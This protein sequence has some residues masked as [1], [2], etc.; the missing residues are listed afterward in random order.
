[1]NELTWPQFKRLNHIRNLTEQQQVREYRFYLDALSNERLRQ[2]KGQTCFLL[3]EN[4]FYL[5]QE[6]GNRIIWCF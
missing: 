1:M 6:D 5:L 3:Q 2:S 4:K